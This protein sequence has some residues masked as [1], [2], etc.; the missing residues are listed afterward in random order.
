M[1]IYPEAAFAEY[2]V[3]DTLPYLRITFVDEDGVARDL[4]AASAVTIRGQLVDTDITLIQKVMTAVTDGSDGVFEAQW[5]ATDL[6]V[7][8]GEYELEREI[9]WGG[10][11]QPETLP[12]KLKMILHAKFADKV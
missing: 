11:A 3:G 7:T 6:A 10:G 8:A 4:S 9:D 1:S 5:G 12:G 2:S